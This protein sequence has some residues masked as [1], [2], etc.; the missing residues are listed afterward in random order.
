MEG[1]G[2]EKNE[3]ETGAWKISNFINEEMRKKNNA[4]KEEISKWIY[5][6]Q[7]WLMIVTDHNDDGDHDD[8]TRNKIEDTF[9]WFKWNRAT[10]KLIKAINA[11]ARQ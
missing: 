6:R 11:L 4:K 5:C 10:H 1:G 2:V 9:A 3:K 8:D 7:R